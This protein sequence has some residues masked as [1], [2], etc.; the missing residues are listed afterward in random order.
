[1]VTRGRSGQ[2]P[3][4]IE[5]QN[6]WGRSLNVNNLYSYRA[7]LL[8]KRSVLACSTSLLGG[9]KDVHFLSDVSCPKFVFE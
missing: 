6:M 5:H 9:E 1:M 4:K 3:K 2:F 8:S 7:I